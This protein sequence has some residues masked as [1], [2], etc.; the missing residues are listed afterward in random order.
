M[1]IFLITEIVGGIVLYQEQA[2]L[3]NDVHNSIRVAVERHYGN[4]LSNTTKLDL[5]QEAVSCAA[6]LFIICSR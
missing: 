6:L 5:I 3:Q 4:D 2:D 1:A